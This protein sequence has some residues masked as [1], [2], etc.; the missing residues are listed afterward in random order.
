LVFTLIYSTAF[1]QV[2]KGTVRLHNSGK[3]PVSGVFIVFSEAKAAESDVNG[4]FRLIFSG[5]K[6]GDL[7]FKERIQKQGYELVNAKE[8]EVS[9]ISSSEQFGEDVILAVAGTLDAAKKQ[10]YNISDQALLA[11]FEKQK[12]A[13]RDEL[14]KAKLNQEEFTK[15]FNALQES[16]E[17]QR[18]NLDDLAEKFARIDFDDTEVFYKEAFDFYKEGKIEEAIKKLESVN[19]IKRTE[20]RL[21]ERE[22]IRRADSILQAQ[23]EANEAGLRRDIQ[24][25]ELQ[26]DMYELQNNILKAKELYE[27]L[28]KLDSTHLESLNKIA[29]FYYKNSFY[30]SAI[31]VYTSLINHQEIKEW[32]IANIYKTLGEIY[33]AIGKQNECLSSHSKALEM[34]LKLNETEANLSYKSNLALAYQSLAYIYGNM[35]NTQKRLELYEKGTKLFQELAEKAPK[36]NEIKFYL[37]NSYDL[38]GNHYIET[39]NLTKAFEL[40]KQANTL[41][42][43]LSQEFPQSF[44]YKKGVA[45]SFLKLGNCNL[46]MGKIDQALEDYQKNHFIFDSLHREMP[47]FLEFK[48]KLA[49]ANAK[50]GDIFRA[51]EDFKN[52]LTYYQKF[53]QLEQE[54]SEAYPANVYYK[55]YLAISY[56]YVNLSHRKLGNKDKLLGIA[57][58]MNALFRELLLIYPQNINFKNGLIASY[59]EIGDAYL[60]NKEFVK[61]TEAYSEFQKLMNELA[62]TNP[63]NIGYK[64]G[65]AIAHGKLGEGYR[66][67]GNY[68]KAKENLRLA[69]KS[70]QDLILAYP[71]Y[72]DFQQNIA[73]IDDL[74]Y[75]TYNASQDWQGQ[76]ALALEQAQRL[77]AQNRPQADLADAYHRVA[78]WA[79]YTRQFAEAEK[80]A[81]LALATDST[82]EWFNTHLALAYLFQGKYEAAESIYNR[83]KDQAYDKDKKYKAVFLN[84]LKE[85]EALGISHEDVKRVRALLEK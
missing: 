66:L 51:R 52:A 25:L 45:L 42:L 82:L 23:K 68:P 6:A 56:Q 58:K 57:E 30:Q 33:S 1:A 27:Q 60:E 15:K 70:W 55:Q 19:L 14:Q 36:D 81:R 24:A 32:Q 2:Q 4:V 3:K 47:N 80:Y 73:L 64:S 29:F 17:Q 41:N 50:L 10:Y 65:V 9:K 83:L 74:L 5:K 26:A 77:Q 49:L 76:L 20:K 18:K 71:Q 75:R 78:R 79:L 40:Y 69:K 12:K 84:D 7:I 35:A 43:Q 39:G 11:N 37:A 44:D 61:S 72:A 22:R 63:Q 53:N 13:L 31:R 67:A 38:L 8:L 59:Q 85:L 28:Y 16:Y 54:L 46:A 48:D 21:E 34:F 62:T